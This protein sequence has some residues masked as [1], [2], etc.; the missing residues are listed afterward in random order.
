MSEVNPLGSTVKLDE[1]RLVF[2]G[3]VEGSTT[4]YVAFRNS[5]GE[6][7]KLKLSPEAL[8]ALNHLYILEPVTKL[9]STFPRND[10]ETRQR[11]ML[12]KETL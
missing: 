10:N 9:K 3:R 2:L 4:W 1:V 11:W 7:T 6:D 5:D 12:V 8:E